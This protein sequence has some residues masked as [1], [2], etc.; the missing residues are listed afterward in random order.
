MNTDLL[1]PRISGTVI[2]ALEPRHGAEADALIWNGRKPRR[3]AKIIVRAA[4]AG[5]VAEAVRFAAAN[6]LTVSPRGGGH[7]FTGI[8]AQADMV[9]DLGALDG[10]KLDT[11]RRTARVEPAVTNARMAAALERHGLA[12]PLGHCG[13]VPMSGY[14]LGGGVGWNSAEWGFACFS[15]VAVEVVLADGRLVRA[16]AEENADIFWAVRGAGPEFFGVVTAYHLRLREAAKATSTTIRVYPASMVA[17]IA[18]WAEDVVARAP[19]CVEFTT[20]VTPT[21]TGPVLA[22]IATVFAKTDAE[23]CAIHGALGQGAPEALQVIGPMPTPM[24]TLY[25][26]TEPSMPEGRRYAVDTLWS[27]ARYGEVLGRVAQDMALA[28]SAACMG[29]VVLR[30]NAVETPMDAAFSCH[31][32]IFGAL[33]AIWDCA[34]ADDLNIG[35][36]RTAIDAVAPLCTGAYVGEADLDRPDRMLPTLSAEA[37]ARINELRALHDPRGIFQRRI[38]PM[39]LAAE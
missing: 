2:T 6:G 10:L 24:P 13:S 17:E 36:L 25:E 34:E 16:S 19:A 12:F 37:K 28:P 33:Y 1:I 20:K 35:W 18:A 4:C 7:Q 38:T 32:R 5:D 3:R 21:P 26:A 14:L 11:E 39:A 27:D 23:A 8:A 30:S 22:A 29:L 9:I 31:G 15:V